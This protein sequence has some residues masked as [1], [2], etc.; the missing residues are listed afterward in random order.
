MLVTFLE[1]V[2]EV[3]LEQPIKA[4]ELSYALLRTAMV[5]TLSGITISSN[6]SQP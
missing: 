3:K 4:S 6:S 5:F 2:M 1:M